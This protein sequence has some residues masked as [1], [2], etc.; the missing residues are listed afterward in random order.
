M[1]RRVGCHVLVLRTR[2]QEP[3][4]AR[5]S[6]NIK[7]GSLFCLLQSWLL[8]RVRYHTCSHRPRGRLGARVARR[9]QKGDAF[10]GQRSLQI[11]RQVLLM[12]SCHCLPCECQRAHP[13]IPC[14]ICPCS[15]PCI[16][17]ITC[18]SQ[19]W[20]STRGATCKLACVG[21]CQARAVAAFP[22][23]RVRI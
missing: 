23:T 4:R 2:Q 19:Q 11:L 22:R 14:T 13:R 16:I 20:P 15:R 1:I 7:S 5:G 3:R 9:I 21:R 17:D 10:A 8:E 6:R 18:S 12:A